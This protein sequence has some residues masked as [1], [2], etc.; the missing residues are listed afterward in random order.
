MLDLPVLLHLVVHAHGGGL[1]DGDHHRLARKPRPMKCSTMSSATF[2]SRSSRVIRWYSRAELP[3]QLGAPGPR[4]VRLFQQA[5]HVLVEV[6][7]DQLQFGDAVL[8]VERDGGAVLHR[9]LE[10]VDADVIAEDLR[11]RSSPA[12][13]GVPV[14]PMKAALGRALRML[15]AS[16][17]YWLRCASSVMT[18][19]SSARTAPGRF[20]RRRCGT[21]GS[22]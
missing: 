14:K 4:P 22:G 20:A 9:L 13:S 8:V 21:C 3:L 17:S 18:M 15:S 19:M 7:V 10:V 16:V 2:S 11:V 12:I 5:L 1:V 6:L